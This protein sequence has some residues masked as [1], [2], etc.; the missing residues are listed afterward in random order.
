VPAEAIVDVD[1]RDPERVPI[2]W[3]PGAGA[4]FTTGRP[5][6]PTHP[7]ADRLAVA[8]QDGDPASPLEL[9]RRLI[10]LRRAT[11]ALQHGSFRAVRAAPDVFAYVREHDADRVLIALNFAPFP[12]PLP[13]EADGARVLL[14]TV[15]EPPAGELA[16]DEARILALN[17][18]Y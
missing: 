5:W 11:P 2:P 7:D 3:T 15:G 9:Y 17:R 6:L 1:G 8:V 10:S 14:S 12:R 13:D 16:G 4:G 18:V